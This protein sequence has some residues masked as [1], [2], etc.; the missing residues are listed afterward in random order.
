MG[1]DIII[2]GIETSCDE[3]SCAVVKNGREVLSNVVKSQVDIHKNFG[4]VVPEIASRN[5]LIDINYVAQAALKEA[6][7]TMRDIDA[8][9]VTYGAGLLGALLVGVSFAK[10]LSQN[11]NL[12]LIKVNHIE[13]HICANYL[14]Y[15]E[16]EP[17]FCCLLASGGHT[18]IALVDSYVSCRVLNNSIDDACGEAFDKVARTLGLGYPGGQKLD[19]LAQEGKDNTPFKTVVMNNGD[20]SYS[21]LKTGV[22]NHLNSAKQKNEKIVAADIAKSFEV[23]AI[24]GLVDRALLLTKEN[25]LEKVCVAGGVGANTYLRSYIVERAKESNLSVYLPEL[26][27]CGDNA[28][29]IASRA[30][31]SFSSK[32]D[33]SDYDLNA[34]PSLRLNSKTM[35]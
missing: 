23:A 16:L 32:I 5:H 15:K 8:I 20:F 9:G 31:F 33:I 25:G 22:L 18:A 35:R 26:I 2:F 30:F 24:K 14:T 10:G 17:P 7:V 29:M 21:G 28:A 13:G 6:G 34:E 3:T 12:P 11:F 1:K 19:V 27:Y 4:G